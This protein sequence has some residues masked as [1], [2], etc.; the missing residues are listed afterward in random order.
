MI[1]SHLEIAL[2]K[3]VGTKQ[4]PKIVTPTECLALPDSI[5]RVGVA[6]SFSMVFSWAPGYT[7][8]TSLDMYSRIIFIK[9]PIIDQRIIH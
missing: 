2:V 7:L 5:N 3:G 4:N 6:H 8:T 9:D 1:S